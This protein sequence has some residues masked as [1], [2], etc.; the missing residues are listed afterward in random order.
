MLNLKQFFGKSDYV[1]GISN[2]YGKYREY[3]TYLFFGCL[4]AAVNLITYR[5]LYFSA[6]APNLLSTFM[7]WLLAVSFAFLTNRSFVFHSGARG[8]EVIRESG[9]FFACRIFTG[10]IDLVFMHITVSVLLWD[11]TVSKLLS[12][13][14]STVL[15][16]ILS[17]VII[18]KER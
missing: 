13:A 18:F 10:A 1:K 16:Y 17:K 9:G 4:T 15:N 14:I 11:G 6:G 12:T 5:F 3:I 8:R 2:L 7:A